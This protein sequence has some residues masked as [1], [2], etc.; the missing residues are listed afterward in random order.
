MLKKIE[1]ESIDKEIIRKWVKLNYKDPYNLNDDIIIPDEL[2]LE[3]S[4]KY[5]QLYNIITGESIH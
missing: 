1:P 3:L 5:I 4:L 2:R